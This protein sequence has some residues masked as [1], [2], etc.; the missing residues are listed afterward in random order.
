MLPN[1]KAIRLNTFVDVP[2]EIGLP[3]FIQ[4]DHMDDG[5]PL[6]GNFKLSLQSVVC[7]RGT[8]VD[9]GHYISLVRATARDPEAEANHWLRFDDLGSQKITLIDVH[10]A[11]RDETPYLLF[12]QIIPI[13]GDPGNLTS[14]EKPPSYSEAQAHDSGVSV[15]SGSP[16]MTRPIIESLPQSRRPSLE[17]APEDRG[18]EP[19]EVRR[20]SVV[21]FTD[22]SLLPRSQSQDGR[23]KSLSLGRSLSRGSNAISKRLSGITGSTKAKDNSSLSSNSE[24]EIL[25]TEEAEP[26]K[27]PVIVPIP[28]PI[29]QPQPQPS[30]AIDIPYKEPAHMSHHKRD[31]SK[32]RLR[33]RNKGANPDRE[34]NVM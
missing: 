15:T 26:A 27:E 21:S 32:N 4:D 25:I 17:L 24:S 9:S 3:H 14:G 22:T 1:G 20:P 10:K 13:D 8:S 33:G 6:Y 12:Y 28:Q 18:R 31:K 2:V 7:H 29:S 16:E 19:T 5:G 34:C 30:K 23:R 11:L